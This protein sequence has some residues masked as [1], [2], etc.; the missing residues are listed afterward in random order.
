MDHAGTESDVCNVAYS[1]SCRIFKWY[2]DN[3]G[4]ENEH[5]H[6]EALKK[7]KYFEAIIH[8]LEGL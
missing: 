1:V 2:A 5:S 6:V 4:S 8:L 3:V 7:E